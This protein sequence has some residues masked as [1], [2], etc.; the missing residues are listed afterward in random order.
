MSRMLN[1]DLQVMRA[2]GR[3]EEDDHWMVKLT[4]SEGVRAE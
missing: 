2:S 1:H 4:G 3:S